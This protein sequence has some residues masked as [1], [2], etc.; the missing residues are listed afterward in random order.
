MFI[1]SL[2]Y[3]MTDILLWKIYRYI[4]SINKYM[5]ANNHRCKSF[6]MT[7]EANN[8]CKKF[9]CVFFL[10][11]IDLICAC[12]PLSYYFLNA[13][14]SS[15]SFWPNNYFMDSNKSDISCCPYQQGHVLS[16]YSYSFVLHFNY[17]TYFF[18][19]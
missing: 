19:L 4:F 16:S 1:Y 8:L 15:D 2:S 18:G 9:Y 6:P 14:Y 12:F 13:F 10:T 5:H 11:K 7:K 3:F 17:S